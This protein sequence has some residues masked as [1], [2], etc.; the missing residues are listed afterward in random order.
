LILGIKIKKICSI[1]AIDLLP[2][3]YNCVNLVSIDIYECEGFTAPDLLRI[4]KPDAIVV[5]KLESAD[6]HPGD[7]LSRFESIE[8]GQSIRQLESIF[9]SLSFSMVTVPC[10]TSSHVL[11]VDPDIHPIICVGCS[12][13]LAA[14][15]DECRKETGV[16]RCACGGEKCGE[17]LCAECGPE[18]E[19][20]VEWIAQE[21]L[22][23]EEPPVR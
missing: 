7:V 10:H 3:L 1:R 22:Y 16:R 13:E 23:E 9:A 18:C 4:L 17:F 14:I 5:C 15:C 8:W 19:V 21:C 6:L 20:C 12:K 11:D 2:A